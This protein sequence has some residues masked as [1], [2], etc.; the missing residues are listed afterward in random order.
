VRVLNR[1]TLTDV[2]TNLTTAQR[3]AIQNK[4]LSMG[5]TQAEINAAM[6][7]NLAAWRT[8]TLADLLHLVATRRLKPRYDRANDLIVLD[9]D[10]VT[11]TAVELVAARVA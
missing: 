6:G 11:P 7:T 4:L 3:N 1:W 2:L 9:G 10:V 8:H 5:Y